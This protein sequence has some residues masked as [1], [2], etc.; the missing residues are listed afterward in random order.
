MTIAEYTEAFQTNQFGDKYLYSVNQEDF[1]HLGAENAFQQRMGENL[2]KEHYLYLVI[3]S[4]SGLLPEYIFK[5]GLP[6]GSRYIFIEPTPLAN[7]L[8][9]R[10]EG[11]HE[12]IIIA[13]PDNALSSLEEQTELGAAYY[14]YRDQIEIIQSLGCKSDHLNQYNQIAI[15]ALEEVDAFRYEAQG[16]MFLL[17]HY[18]NQIANLVDEPNPARF[19]ANLFQGKTAVILA[20]GPSLNTGF[21]WIKEHRKE[22]LVIAVSRVCRQLVAEEITPD[23]VVTTDPTI[24]SYEISRELFQLKGCL[25]TH[26]P[27]SIDQLVS[28]WGGMKTYFGPRLPWPSKINSDNL[29][30]GGGNTIANLA[31]DLAAAT[32]VGQI[33][34]FGMN[35]CYAT[36]G[37]THATGS[38]E[39][40]S[41]PPIQLDILETDTNNGSRVETT[42]DL[43]QSAQYLDEQGRKLKASGISIIN[44]APDAIRLEHIEH[45]PV[46]EI[47]LQPMDQM[48][49][50]TIRQAYPDTPIEEYL[51]EV[52][53]TLTTSESQLQA[54]K[55]NATRGINILKHISAGKKS[56]KNPFALIAKIRQRIS[57]NE[58]SVPTRQVVWD[59]FSKIALTFESSKDN[60]ATNEQIA[61]EYFEACLVGYHKLT[62]LLGDARQRL[63]CR[64][65][66]LKQ[67]PNFQLLFAQWE[68]DRQFGRAVLWKERNRD[69]LVNLDSN[70]KEQL[71]Q[72]ISTF[73]KESNQSN[74][75]HAKRV[76]KLTNIN[77]ALPKSINLYIQKNHGGLRRLHNILNHYPKSEAKPFID[78]CL[79]MLAE[80]EGDQTEAIGHYEKL[81]N[82]D[83]NELLEQTLKRISAICIETGNFENAIFAIDGLTHISNRYFF[84]S[85]NVLSGVGLYSEAYEAYIHYFEGHPN[86]T[87]AI[88]N[89]GM[90]C[91]QLD[92]IDVANQALARLKEINP[93]SNEYIKLSAEIERHNNPGKD[94]EPV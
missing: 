26:M 62:E 12:K 17:H 34:L 69:Q 84:D 79:G 82:C 46:S 58:M 53:E 18:K 64:R 90:L 21:P 92:K 11:L 2:F 81:L 49:I 77:I 22:L 43:Y 70:T 14:A 24:M 54:L 35:F 55:K 51:N 60:Q 8:R 73:D 68:K 61:K 85:A 45:R 80:L 3:G 52:E 86:D 93:E 37:Y 30:L 41:P 32:G 25:F 94:S 47:C 1:N 16:S 88:I 39:S 75:K 59:V 56:N 72:M 42:P 83:N 33:V 10:I 71:D 28:Q 13:G 40:K 50:E 78:F 4:D 19:L 65:E 36:D 6:T 20:G 89:F 57:D 87:T 44:P 67:E 74:T 63:T 27:G 48:A 91:I 7:R 29:L 5:K 38:N 76:K 66:E 31:T 15:K 9:L 23:I